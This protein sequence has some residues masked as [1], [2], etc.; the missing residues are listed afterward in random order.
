M[1]SDKDLSDGQPR[2]DRKTIQEWKEDCETFYREWMAS[3]E[4]NAEL[5]S[6]NISLEIRNLLLMGELRKLGKYP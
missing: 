1:R 5:H 6:R 3:Q 4:K 2:L